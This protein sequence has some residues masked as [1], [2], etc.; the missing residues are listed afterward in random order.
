MGRHIARAIIPSVVSPSSTPSKPVAA[1]AYLLLTLTPL[2]WSISWILGRGLAS[3]IPP[4]AMTFFR[5]LFSALI[6]APFA[7]PTMRRDWPLVRRHWKALLFLAAVGIA[8]HN[9]LA[10]LGLNYTTATNGVILNSFIP[11]MIVALSWLFLRDPLSVWQ[12][13]GLGISLTGV[14]AILS[15]GSIDTLLA[16]RLNGGD[17]VIILSMAMWAIYTIC[18][19]WQPPGMHAYTL[20]FVLIC[21]GVACVFPFFVAE[22]LWVRT[23]AFTPANLGA[24]LTVALFSSVLAYIFWNRGVEQIGANVAG[25]FVH[26]M[27]VYGVVLAWMFLGESL[28]LY[29]L[30]GISLI[31][32]GIWITSRS[33]RRPVP[34]PAPID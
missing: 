1:N 14:L 7:W 28:A 31:L 29:H 27:P 20:L 10:Y 15:Q 34:A 26:L 5:W 6:L 30:V 2:L 22:A 11:V 25:L 23:M 21:L 3:D 32:V 9:G 16:F 12:M 19:R 8:L 18:L 24:L 33:G 4:M 13:I 17:L